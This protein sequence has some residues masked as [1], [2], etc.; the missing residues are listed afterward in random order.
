MNRIYS[1]IWNRA[2]HTVQVASELA[3]SRQGGGGASIGAVR[4]RR[5]PLALACVAALGMA[6]LALPAWSAT[7][8]TGAVAVPSPSLGS[9]GAAGS[10]GSGTAG[11]T[12]VNGTAG[13][14]LC[15]ESGNLVAGGAGGE[16]AATGG[17]GGLGGVAVAGSN[18]KLINFGYVFGGAGGSGPATGSAGGIGGDGISGDGLTITNAV[19]ARIFGGA[20][21][22]GSVLGGAGG[23][24]IT[25]NNLTLVNEGD[26]EAGKGGATG[27]GIILGGGG[28]GPAAVGP[29]AQTSVATT[30]TSGGD[31]TGGAGG[32]GVYATGTS[33]LTNSAGALIVGGEGES[34]GATGA[35]GT[36]LGGAG[37]MGVAGTG[38]KLTNQ[39]NILGGTGGAGY[40]TYGVN[41]SNGTGGA[42]GAAVSGSGF[43]VNNSAG[44]YGGQGGAGYAFG[45]ATG[46][47]GGAG[48]AGSG[49]T[50]VN[51]RL[52]RGGDGGNAHDYVSGSSGTYGYVSTSGAGGAGIRVDNAAGATS[53]ISNTSSGSIY[54][55]DGKYAYEDG[56]APAA[57]A[58]TV[59]GNGGNGGAGIAIG[60]AGTTTV[61]NAGHLGGGAGGYAYV[62]DNGTCSTYTGH[63]G[64]GGAGINVAGSGSTAVTNTGY[65]YGGRG[66]NAWSY[67]TGYTPGTVGAGGA[68]ISVSGTGTTTITNSGA[69]YGGQAGGGY[70]A[71]AGVAGAGVRGTGFQL[72]NS[73][74]IFGGDGDEVG[75]V[76]GDLGGAGGAGVSGYG[77]T[78]T[79]TGDIY[80][81]GGR[82]ASSSPGGVGQGGAGIDG[83]GR[84]S[85][86]TSGLIAG[87]R[88]GD[89][90]T[91]ADAVDFSGGANTLTLESGYSFTGN[92]ISSSGTTNGGDTLALGGATNDT[93]D[94]A[95]IAATAPTSWT[96]TMQYFGFANYFKVDSSTWT[97]TNT[98]TA[99][100]PWTLE[101]GILQISNDDNLG[102]ASGGLTFNGGTLEN[103]AAITM[104]RSVN[105]AGAGTWQMDANVTDSG[106]VS[107]AGSL[108]KTGAGT[109]IFNGN[110]SAFSGVMAVNDGTVIVGDDGFPGATLGGTMT[111]A[112]GATVGGFGTLGSLDLFGNLS[113]GHSIGTL[114]ATGSATFEP[115]STYLLDV[116]PNGTSDQFDAQGAV[117]IKGG[118]IAAQPSTGTWAPITR[119]TI[120]TGDG[121]VTGTFAGLTGAPTAHWG[122]A[123]DPN[124]VYLLL[125][126]DAFNLAG[127]GGT[128]NERNTAGGINS[129]GW[130]SQLFLA[131]ASLDPSAVPAAFDQTSGE[132][133]ASQQAA[134]VN[135][136]RFVREQ[137]NKRV[138]DGDADAEGTTVAGTKLTLWAHGW[139]HW[140]QLDGDGNAAQMSDNGDGLLVGAD[141]PIDTVGRIGFTGGAERNSLSVRDR[142]SW[143]DVTQTWLGT[144]GGFE[145]GPFGF[146]A[147]VAYAWNQ[148]P[149]YRDLYLPT[150]GAQHLSSNA[151]GSTVTGFVEG[152]WNIQTAFGKLAPYLNLAGVRVH[153]NASDEVG[154]SA[155]LH[156]DSQS[157]STTLSTL[158]VRGNWQL[159]GNLGLEANVG[160]RHAFGDV[161]PE[162]TQQFIA[163]GDG[164]T[165]Y[166]TPLS[167]NAGQVNVNLTWQVAPNSQVVLGYDGLYGSGVK[168]TAAKASFNVAF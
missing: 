121:G 152:A 153:S 111:V 50:V 107:G 28:P 126:T 101:G 42:G 34:A 91:Q 37:G 130:G 58:V 146:R 95:Q 128:I 29:A 20:G 112:A 86:I 122:I 3:T 62:C 74:R 45:A 137:M 164:F 117:T 108:T 46:G 75:S 25:G 123:Y 32:T 165:V 136:S 93:F 39:G 135:D 105:V 76:N 19:G 142:S 63:G 56:V 109:L 27:A 16:G 119:Y 154:G 158:G 78:V 156:M 12:A 49:F 24:G 103:T 68:G 140:G 9:P 38:F 4:V 1:L 168:D 2:L 53:S 148:I 17:N 51:S 131:M 14:Y 118:T 61:T 114:S 10:N 115:G 70:G 92:A 73:G 166:G 143:A 6:T 129:L 8:P 59:V 147:G 18:L 162:R 160:W 159:A 15:V 23:N 48:I 47:A 144:Y 94:V 36:G 26:I 11:G 5:H 79:N 96:G 102:A 43:Y 167:K 72:T 161:T 141:L 84:V 125:A 120:V 31:A 110:G 133:N 104:A 87:G 41:G 81:G 150:L 13:S 106:S 98:T 116:S 82:Y 33:N 64:A 124:H 66:G 69:I 65:I 67:G 139:G 145:Q 100:T 60:G 55:G 155:A 21:G 7:C 151:T 132:F 30:A 127:S 113:P 35:G 83:M 163:G 99:V 157:M 97:L 90:K 138:R 40:G 52:I 134:L 54:G 77:F 57:A 80:G 22:A 149:A 44:I 88:S 89:G 71:P 85:V